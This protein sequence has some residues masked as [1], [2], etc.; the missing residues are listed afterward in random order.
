MFGRSLVVNDDDDEVFDFEVE[1]EFEVRFVVSFVLPV[2]ETV[3]KELQLS[4]DED[5]DGE[6]SYAAKAVIIS[7][8]EGTNVSIPILA[9]SKTIKLCERQ[10]RFLYVVFVKRDWTH[11][12]ITITEYELVGYSLHLSMDRSVFCHCRSLFET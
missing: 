3:D 1:F 7:G 6:L 8:K 4:R 10:Q 5:T 2:V 11:P 12:T 9:I